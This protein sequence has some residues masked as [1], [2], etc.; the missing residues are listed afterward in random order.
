[1]E[2]I[3]KLD[4]I[5]IANNCYNRKLKIGEDSNQVTIVWN[6]QLKTDRAITNN[7]Q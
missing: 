6:M 2:Y 1:M 7:K 5:E 4:N 3:C